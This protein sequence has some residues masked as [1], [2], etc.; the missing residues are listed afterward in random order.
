M[1]PI[2]NSVEISRPPEDVFAYVTDPTHLPEWV[3]VRG[4]PFHPGL[5]GRGHPA[6]GPH[7]EGHDE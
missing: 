5:P 3:S 2:V 4:R 1:A 7:G 6:R